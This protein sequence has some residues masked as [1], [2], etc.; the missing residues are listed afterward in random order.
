MCLCPVCWV[1]LIVLLK[2][3]MHKEFYPEILQVYQILISRSILASVQ[4]TM[5]LVS[6]FSVIPHSQEDRLTLHTQAY[7]SV[8]C[9]FFMNMLAYL[10]CQNNFRGIDAQGRI[11]AFLVPCHHYLAWW[12]RVSSSLQCELHYQLVHKLSGR[13]RF[14]HNVGLCIQTNHI[15]HCAFPWICLLSGTN[16]VHTFMY[17]L[18]SKML[19]VALSHSM[20]CGTNSKTT[21][22]ILGTVLTEI[23]LFANIS[24]LKKWPTLYHL[25]HFSNKPKCSAPW[26]QYARGALIPE[27]WGPPAQIW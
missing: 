21:K 6:I 4:R 7:S 24:Q 15:L 13:F 18:S 27:H 2:G 16:C 3:Y 19:L 17:V 11:T 9:Y 5:F 26:S 8:Q 20:K 1:N 14:V 25:W 23:K 12:H 10:L 22:I